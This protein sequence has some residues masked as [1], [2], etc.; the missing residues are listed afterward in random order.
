MR[1]VIRLAK[2]HLLCQPVRSLFCTH[3]GKIQAIKNTFKLH[4]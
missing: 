3:A 1:L 4:K 2:P